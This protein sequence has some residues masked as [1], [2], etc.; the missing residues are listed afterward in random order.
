[1]KRHALRIVYQDFDI[2]MERE[3]KRTMNRYSDESSFD[4]YGER[5]HVYLYQHES[6]ALKARRRLKRRMGSKIQ[7]EIKEHP[8]NY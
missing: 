2:S 3:I 4:Q 8:I 7:C 6:N 5:E 1:M